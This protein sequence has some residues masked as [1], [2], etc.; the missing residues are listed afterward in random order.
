M[1]K[2]I[3]LEGLR[4]AGKT[5]FLNKLKES[6]PEFCCVPELYIQT[7]RYDPDELIREKYAKAEIQKKKDILN[8]NKH[9]VYD[10]SF[11]STLAFAYAKYRITGNRDD[12]DFYRTF[13]SDNRGNIVMPDYIFVFTI[14]P[15]VS[16]ERGRKVVRDNTLDFWQNEA[17]LQNFSDFY[18]SDECKYVVNEDKI[19][20]V[21]TMNRTE[22][23]TYEFIINMLREGCK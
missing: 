13:L 11:L 18:N 8:I 10:R 16:I 20:S 4:C 23:E 21:D 15:K 22:Q 19:I 17:F 9:V 3:A 7:E 14:T 2:I 5:T 12:H 6:N 1:R